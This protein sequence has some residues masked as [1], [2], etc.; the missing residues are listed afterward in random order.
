MAAGRL[1]NRRRFLASTGALGSALAWAPGAAQPASRKGPAPRARLGINLAGPSDF[2]TELPFVDVARL[3]REWIS[4]R[5][6]QGWG[7]GPPLALD[8]NGWVRRL[9]PGCSADMLLLTE[10]GRHVPAGLYNI[11]YTGKGKLSFFDAG[12]KPTSIAPGHIALRVDGPDGFRIRLEETDPDDPL[13]DLRVIRPGFEHRYESDPWDP[14]FL[15]RWSGVSVIRFT[16]FQNAGQS[17]LRRW[18]ERPRMQQATFSTKGV[19]IELAVDLANR[20]RADPW[21]SIPHAADDDVVRQFAAL[22]RER[23]DP[24]RSVWLEYSNE[25]WNSGAP[26]HRYTADRGMK[27]GL[28]EQP[29]EA[30]V[31]FTALR[32]MKIFQIW[33]GV[34]GG[35][36]RLVR[37]LPSQAANAGVSEQITGF[38]GAGKR[39]D[40]LAIAPYLTLVAGPETKPTARDIARWSLDRLFDHLGKTTL[41]EAV[42]WMRANKTVADRYGLRLVAYEGGQHLVGIQGGENDEA[43]T[44]LFVA[45]NADPRMGELYARYLDA[46]TKAGG[47]LFCHFDSVSRWGKWGSWG[48]LQFHD[49]RV[50][51][52]PKFLAT[53]DWARARGQQMTASSG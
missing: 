3:S 12:A 47:D 14:A 25:T 26:A 45:A 40:A 1:L 33:E 42:G 28:A 48:L 53:L 19:A 32:S 29:W 38:R 37:V 22:V 51:T 9:E 11:R 20:L 50:Q 52:S 43:L 6:N 5:N 21:F 2:A 30:A 18:S 23:L 4:Q 31:A 8:A 36:K 44:R 17:T 41:P 39:A 34:F 24:A 46:W 35:A 10:L 16:S 13:R 15:K 7:Q 27:L 49:D